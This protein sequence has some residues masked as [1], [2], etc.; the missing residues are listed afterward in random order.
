MLSSATK[1]SAGLTKALAENDVKNAERDIESN[2]REFIDKVNTYA[3]D[4]G[5]KMRG[6]F[7]R[8]VD[9]TSRFSHR[10]ENEIKTN[11]V[12]SS[13]L[14]LGAGFILGALLTSRR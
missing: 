10:V 9:G 6:A 14:A 7:D 13:A 4:A 12:R 3:N 8:T 1:A 2:G 11:P 5:Q